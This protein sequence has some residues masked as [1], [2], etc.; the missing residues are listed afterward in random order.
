MEIEM[1]PELA[2]G[3]FRKI[4]RLV[5]IAPE[6]VIDLPFG[7]IS[8]TILDKGPGKGQRKIDGPGPA[9]AAG[10]AVTG[11]EGIVLDAD[12]G[13]DVLVLI[14]VNPAHQ[15]KDDMRLIGG[16]KGIAMEA[17]AGGGGQFGDDVV[18]VEPHFII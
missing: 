17:D 10:L 15:V 11:D 14:V 18:V 3:S 12:I 7:K 16:G 6:A 5:P 13:P 8:G 9:P 1:H 2:A 4:V